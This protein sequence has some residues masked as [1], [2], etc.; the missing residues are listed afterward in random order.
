MGERISR[1]RASGSLPQSPQPCSREW[2]HPAPFLLDLPLQNS[3]ALVPGSSEML[4]WVHQ[5]PPRNWPWRG[6][7]G[8]MEGGGGRKG[9]M[10]GGGR[11]A[12]AAGESHSVSSSHLSSD[13]LSEEPAGGKNDQ[14][15]QV[16]FI[17]FKLC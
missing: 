16:Q 9:G 5:A 10:E 6:G 8:R 11:K 12:G 15:N 4:P 14:K 7:Q 3:A 13:H 17:T 2:M 1:A